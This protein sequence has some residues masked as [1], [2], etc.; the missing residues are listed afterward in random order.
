MDQGDPFKPR[1]PESDSFGVATQKRSC[2]DTIKT[3]MNYTI[4]Q[5]SKIGE[6]RAQSVSCVVILES[7]LS[8]LMTTQGGF[9]DSIDQDQTAQNV[10]SDL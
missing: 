1:F 3:H 2:F 6:Y 5:F 10:Q 4:A 7:T 8:L 9:V